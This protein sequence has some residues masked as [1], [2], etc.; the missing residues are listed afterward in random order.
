MGFREALNAF[1][2]D[3]NRV[4]LIQGFLALKVSWVEYQLRGEL[5]IQSVID[6]LNTTFAGD[7]SLDSEDVAIFNFEEDENAETWVFIT[8]ADFEDEEE[9]RAVLVFTPERF[10]WRAA[11]LAAKGIRDV[12][13]DESVLQPYC[14]LMLLEGSE[15]G[16]FRV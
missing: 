8:L 7:F 12:F 13:E 2:Q 6:I 3:L 4:S 10:I 14:G 11:Q 5:L 1:L 16:Q 9:A 15:L